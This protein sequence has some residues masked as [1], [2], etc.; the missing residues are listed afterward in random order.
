MDEDIRCG[1]DAEPGNFAGYVSGDCELRKD[2]PPSEVGL[3]LC[4]KGSGAASES[5]ADAAAARPAS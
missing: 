4:P 2:R 5:A 3:A 1:R